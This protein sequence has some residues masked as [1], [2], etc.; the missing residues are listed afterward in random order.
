MLDETSVKKTIIIFLS[1]ALS[2][3][4]CGFIYYKTVEENASRHVQNYLTEAKKLFQ[5]IPIWH[6]K[7]QT[8]ED[9]KIGIITDTHVHPN[10]IDRND[11]SENAPRYL[12]EKHV[13]PIRNFVSQ[14]QVF[15]PDFVVHLGDVIEGTGDSDTVGIMGLQLVEAELSK[16]GVPIYWA[17]GNHDLRSVTKEQFKETLSLESLD[18]M[19]D[20]GDY[21]F[22]ILDA[23]YSKEN[24]P[25]SPEGGGYIRGNLHPDTIEWFKKQLETDKKVFVFIHHG[26]FPYQAYG[27]DGAKKTSIEDNI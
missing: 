19:F 10:R 22:I 17:V 8:E 21:R 3:F 26:V 1:I 7:I 2:C 4:V 5:A 15:Q 24:T 11:K 14:M 20:V 23:N 18:Q 6:K 12:N 13:K 27:D 25:R 16:A 9:L